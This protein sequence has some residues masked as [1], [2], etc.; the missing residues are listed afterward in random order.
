[1]TCVGKFD[2]AVRRCQQPEGNGEYFG[3][4]ASA[5]RCQESGASSF[6]YQASLVEQGFSGLVLWIGHRRRRALVPKSAGHQLDVFPPGFPRRVF[7]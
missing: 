5:S 4:F 7:Y 3:G 1:M 6:G 2:H